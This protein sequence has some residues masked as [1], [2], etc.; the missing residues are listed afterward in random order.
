MLITDDQCSVAGLIAL[1]SEVRLSSSL[2][3]QVT[4]ELWTVGSQG[5]RVA[6]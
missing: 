5:S 1:V 2:V 6:R 4:W 3:L